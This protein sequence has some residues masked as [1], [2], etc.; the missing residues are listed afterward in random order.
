MTTALLPLPK[1]CKRA[2]AQAHASRRDAQNACPAEV[3]WHR[4]PLH[5]HKGETVDQLEYGVASAE[6]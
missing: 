2:C 4:G 3:T 6:D 1:N 5:L